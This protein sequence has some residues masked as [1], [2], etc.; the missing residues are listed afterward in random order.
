MVKAI[1]VSDLREVYGTPSVLSR[2]L[3]ATTLGSLLWIGVWTTLGA[4]LGK[5]YQSALTQWGSVSW[6][7][8]GAVVVALVALWTWA[9]R[10]AERYGERLA[11]QATQVTPTT[12]TT[13]APKP[14]VRRSQGKRQGRR[15]RL[16]RGA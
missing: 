6:I 16:R 4:V 15:R 11:L 2:Y 1:R 8:L 9:H 3:L 14:T 5:S 13:M 7:A 12:L 10:R